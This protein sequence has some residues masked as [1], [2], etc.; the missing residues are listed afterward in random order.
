MLHMLEDGVVRLLRFLFLC[1]LVS[2]N[3]SNSVTLGLG[4]FND[5]LRE[6][7]SLFDLCF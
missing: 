2:A 3:R 4:L 5:V 1:C 6:L 7:L